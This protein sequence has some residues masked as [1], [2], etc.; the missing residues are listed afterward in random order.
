M[1]N[2]INLIIEF[3][4]GRLTI[5]QFIVYYLSYVLLVLLSCIVLHE[6]G[7]YLYLL[8]YNSKTGIKLGIDDIGIYT[9]TDH[10]L[11]DGELANC[12][13]WGIMFGFVPIAITLDA[14]ILGFYLIGIRRDVYR[15]YQTKVKQWL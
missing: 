6:L 7:H 13:L 9:K 15:L 4:S 3:I 10:K 8:F 2:T 5:M 11:T 14:V 1:I 12:I